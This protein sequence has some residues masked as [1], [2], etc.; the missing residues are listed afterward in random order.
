MQSVSPTWQ[1]STLWILMYRPSSITFS[2]CNSPKMRT[3]TPL[4]TPCTTAPIDHVPNKNHHLIHINSERTLCNTKRNTVTSDVG[5]AG[6]AIT[7]YATAQPPVPK[8]EVVCGRSTG[9]APLKTTTTQTHRH[10]HNNTQ[11]V[12]HSRTHTDR[13]PAN[14]PPKEDITSRRN[15]KAL[16]RFVFG[17]QTRSQS[18]NRQIRRLDA[19]NTYRPTT[20]NT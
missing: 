10:R 1:A 15:Y 7:T 11:T 19:T 14:H 12:G 16:F 5:D 17:C 4:T 13:H 6:A 2:N 20:T 8:H 9:I 18:R 3:S